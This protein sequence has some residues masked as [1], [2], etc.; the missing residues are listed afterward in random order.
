MIV[1]PRA[2]IGDRRNGDL[3]EA[4]GSEFPADFEAPWAR[5]S[6]MIV[7]E[8]H[9]TAEEI[10]DNIQAP[11]AQDE[12][13]NRR[14]RAFRAASTQMQTLQRRLREIAPVG[15]HIRTPVWAI[16]FCNGILEDFT[17]QMR[18]I[19]VNIHHY[20][21]EVFVYIPAIASFSC[22]VE[23]WRWLCTMMNHLGVGVYVSMRTGGAPILMPSGH[24]RYDEWWAAFN[25]RLMD[26]VEF[27]R[28]L[29]V[30]T[31]KK[32]NQKL[33][34]NG[35]PILKFPKELR[36]T[37]RDRI[38]ANIKRVDRETIT[39]WMKVLCAQRGI[40]V[41]HMRSFLVHLILIFFISPL[42][43]LLFLCAV[44]A[45]LYYLFLFIHSLLLGHC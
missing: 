7:I 13:V 12:R 2:L 25:D 24:V 9:S 33:R 6:M 3:S 21:G 35:N 19:A 42:L 22:N 18:Q 36:R 11:Y 39:E 28:T 23:V 30:T 41:I 14:I 26:L 40:P 16:S 1:Q 38:M 37:N 20:P 29:L 10:T 4:N 17:K 43:M 8:R 31:W 45:I 32:R 44:I 27:R 15:N 5:N 34:G